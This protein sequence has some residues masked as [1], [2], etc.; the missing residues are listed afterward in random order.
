[1]EEASWASFQDIKNRF[2]SADVLSGN[3]VIFDIKGN[4]YRLVTVVAYD[5]V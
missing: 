3:R 1:M 5:R 2:R 4:D